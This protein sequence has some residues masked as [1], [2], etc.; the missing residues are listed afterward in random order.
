MVVEGFAVIGAKVALTSAEAVQ[1]ELFLVA[2]QRNTL[3][4]YLADLRQLYFGWLCLIDFY[5]F[6]PRLIQGAFYS[7]LLIQSFLS[8]LFLFLLDMND[9]LQRVAFGDAYLLQL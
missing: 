5:L 4:L 9:H 1:A 6:N 2:L 3:S 8:L 7:R